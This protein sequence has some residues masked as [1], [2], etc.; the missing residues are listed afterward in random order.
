MCMYVCIYIYTH[1]YI[2]IFT[3]TGNQLNGGNNLT[4]MI[5]MQ[6]SYF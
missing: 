1:T 5:G 4:I 6:I 2:Y 3:L